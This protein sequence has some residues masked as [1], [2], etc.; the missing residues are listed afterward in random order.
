MDLK[1]ENAKGGSKV[2]IRVGLV[3]GGPA[4]QGSH[5]GAAEEVWP[6]PLSKNACTAV[7]TKG[8]GFKIADCSDK[9]SGSQTFLRD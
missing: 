4:H 2:F 3:G 8:F 9:I 7:L 6:I 1:G 5:A